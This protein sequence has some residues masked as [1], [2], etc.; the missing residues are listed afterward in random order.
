MKNTIPI[1]FHLFVRIIS[2][3][4]ALNAALHSLNDLTKKDDPVNMC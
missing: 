1:S 2:L 4:T 3:I